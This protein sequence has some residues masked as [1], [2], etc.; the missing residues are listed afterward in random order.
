MHGVTESCGNSRSAEHVI[1]GCADSAAISG[2]NFSSSI[3]SKSAASSA[4]STLGCAHQGRGPRSGNGMH[5]AITISA[6][7]MNFDF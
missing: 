1:D 7:A 2:A 4:N 3:V 5:A 6:A